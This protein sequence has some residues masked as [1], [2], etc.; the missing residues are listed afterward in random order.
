MSHEE[1]VAVEVQ[2]ADKEN[3]RQIIKVAL[4]LFVVTVIEFII[5]FT[6]P[7]SLHG[8]KV[9]IFIALTIVKAGYIIMEF[10]HLGH[11]VKSLIRSILWPMVLILWLIL[12]L[13]FFEADWVFESIFK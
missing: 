3:V 2:P 1:N 5:A 4:I 10:M 9:F 13:V 6:F 11:E 7:A 12:A 8:W